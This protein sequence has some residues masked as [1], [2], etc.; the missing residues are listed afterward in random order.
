MVALAA[1]GRSDIAE[2]R[3][4][5]KPT[6]GSMAPDRMHGSAGTDFLRG[7][8][9]DDVLL[10]GSGRDC[11]YGGAAGDTLWGGAGKDL[12]RG[13]RGPDR[14]RAR[15]GKRDVVH[16]GRG[17]DVAILDLRDALRRPARCERV[18]RPGGQVDPGP[19]P[20]PSIGPE[21][22]SAASPWNTVIDRS[23]V[24][25]NSDAM[26]R[27]LVADGPPAVSSPTVRENWGT[28]VYFSGPGDPLYELRFSGGFDYTRELD[29]KLIHVPS[30]AQPSRGSD[31][32]MWVIDRTDGFLYQTQR[33]QIDH[34]ARRISAW[35]G[36]RV[37]A[38]GLGFG[39]PSAPPTAVQPIRP[40]ELAAGYVDHAMSMEVQCLSGRPVA[41]FDQSLTVGHTCDDGNG[42]LS[43]GS[44]VFLDMTHAQIEALGGPVWQQAILK[45]LADHG[46]VV[47]LNG[48]PGHWALKFQ[49]PLDHT[50][51]GEPDPYAQA[52]LPSTM[53]FS[54]AL[55]SVGGWEEHLKVLEPF[56][57]P[58]P[59]FC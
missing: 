40:E 58:C 53:D 19:N 36:Y 27:N 37:R 1:I 51:L 49:N 11:L 16:C 34:R 43:M 39:F 14:I 46:A 17:D 21:I 15:D 7:R 4:C 24:A 59:G 30:G 31:G 56:P 2:A 57:R 35:K 45:G 44:V 26:I 5:A 28:P 13:G 38:D 23:R 52:G 55:D 32:V 12:L 18:R 9:A 20:R 48:G 10:G 54:D 29:G 33:T 22:F 8:R 42:R 6:V 47:G 3:S 41:P 50:S 25:P